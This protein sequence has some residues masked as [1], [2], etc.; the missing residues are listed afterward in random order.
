MAIGKYRVVK[1]FRQGESASSKIFTEW[2]SAQ[3]QFGNKRAN[4]MCVKSNNVY[5]VKGIEWIIKVAFI[6]LKTNKTYKKDYN[7]ILFQKKK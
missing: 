1:N 2:S 7:E 5:K 3:T 6:W 4:S